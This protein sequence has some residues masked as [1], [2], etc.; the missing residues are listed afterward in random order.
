MRFIN[1]K[2]LA[3]LGVFELVWL[4]D[5]NGDTRLRRKQHDGFGTYACFMGLG[6]GRSTLNEDGTTGGESSYVK[7]WKN[8][9]GNGVWSIKTLLK[10]WR[11]RHIYSRL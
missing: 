5:F 4:S 1:K 8:Y 10:K 11:H 9:D 7:R 2:L 3:R 6:I